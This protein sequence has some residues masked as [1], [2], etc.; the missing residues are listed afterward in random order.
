MS[1]A[2]DRAARLHDAGKAASDNAQPTQAV[3]HLTTALRLIDSDPGSTDLRGRI[4]VSLAF[5]E[6]E[7]GRVAAGFRALDEAEALLPA[8]QRGI[9]FGQRALLFRRIGRDDLALQQF[10]AAV[11]V[12]G[13]QG[14]PVDLIKVLNNR[15]LLH[16]D[17]GRVA[18][19]RSDLRRAGQAA[20]QHAIARYSA[21]I[22]L[23]L[24][25]LDVLSGDLPSALRAFASVRRAYQQ[26]A[27]GR[28]A[29]L[30]VE[31]AKALLAA[32]L[33]AEADRELAA[34]LPSAVEQT[35]ANTQVEIHLA[36]AEAALLAGR[37]RDAA[38][39]A[40]EARASLLGRGNARRAAFAS[41]LELRAD[42]AASVATIGRA[43]TLADQLR[44]LG[45]AEDARVAGLLTAR[46]LSAAGQHGRAER[47]AARNGPPRRG[48]RLDTRLLWRLTRAEL[49]SA[50][51][52]SGDASRHLVAGMNAL[53]RYR[54]QLGCL[55]LQ[56]GAS[57]HGRDLARAG[58]SNALA[59]GSVATVYRWSERV[60]AQALLLPPVR[61]PADPDAAATLEELRQVRQMLR[62]AELAGEPAGGLRARAAA[63][64]R[65]AREHSW[66][67]AGPGAA[68]GSANPV[69]LAAVQAE[70]ADAAM[71]SYLRD[72]DALLALVLAGRSTSIVTLGRYADAAEAVLRLRADL[73]AQAGRAMPKRLAD[74]VLAVTRRD[75]EAMAGL[76]L[77]PVMPLVG[78]RSLVVVPTGILTTVPWAVLPGCAGRPVTV[79]P[80]ATTWSAARCRTGV[81]RTGTLLV[82]GPRNDRGEPEVR[83]IAVLRKQAL[84]LTG[85]AA[86]PAATLAALDGVETAHLAAHGQHQPDNPLFSTL[87]LSG[88]PLLGY[89]LQQIRKAPA[90]VV[91]S[92]CD[93]GLTDIRPGDETLGMAT[94]LLS[95]GTSTVVASVS[96]VADESAMTTM[97]R[98]H[99]A[100]TTG[101]PPAAA[102]ATAITRDDPT[103]FICFG[104]G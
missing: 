104:T 4:L 72:G 79:T 35:L 30:S 73:D 59:S 11:S 18:L 41:L 36:R 39:S 57:V 66:S 3:R 43:R 55:D 9:L 12:L 45:L 83:A 46:M 13:E 7:R 61:P 56:T 32:G 80:S 44:R 48:D 89:D 75:A 93:L 68:A 62:E 90:T 58:L 2:A 34:A 53:H 98:Y 37:S 26:L 96:R 86:T 102:L 28:L 101:H 47:A 77:D 16:L 97:T 71:V 19:A 81:R 60:R 99:E 49:A 51:G 78:D 100:A 82:A 25:C 92:A 10:D 95:A 64:E 40:A 67:V 84:V 87:E 17:A 54:S 103:G 63:L 5:A 6:S 23:N 31:R 22:E 94:A 74:S 33:F 29:N 76:I 52:R 91:L 88:G 50:A 69:P 15:S 85:V 1:D 24:G 20:D 70:L 8:S 65:T 14:M 42:H 27:P 21:I 38:G